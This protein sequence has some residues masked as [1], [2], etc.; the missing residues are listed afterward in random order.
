MIY[1]QR[2]AQT[3]EAISRD[4]N[5]IKVNEEFTTSKEVYETTQEEYER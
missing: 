4:N 2:V 5:S 1:A 3:T